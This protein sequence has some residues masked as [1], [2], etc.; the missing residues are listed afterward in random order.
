MDT[1][2]TLLRRRRNL[3]RVPTTEE[4]PEVPFSRVLREIRDPF[5]EP[6]L[7]GF[8]S[9]IGH[10]AVQ[11]RVPAKLEIG[12]KTFVRL[13]SFFFGSP[14]FEQV[15][16]RTAHFSEKR[17]SKT[18]SCTDFCRGSRPFPVSAPIRL[19]RGR[20]HSPQV[21]PAAPPAP[22]VHSSICI[23]ISREF[24]KQMQTMQAMQRLI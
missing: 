9:G 3:R 7:R 23:R 24:S 13:L 11:N 8:A 10:L 2:F 15:D 17:R 22:R 14:V 5:W 21:A 20:W 4:K 16:G 6:L 1:C 18:G 12:Q 19:I